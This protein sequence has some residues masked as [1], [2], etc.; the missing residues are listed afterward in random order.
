MK[1]NENPFLTESQIYRTS[2]CYSVAN[3][4]SGRIAVIDLG[5]VNAEIVILLSNQETVVATVSLK[6]FEAMNAKLNSPVTALVKESSIVLSSRDYAG[7]LSTRNSLCGK[8]HHITKGAVNADVSLTT[9][10]GLTLTANIAID[11]LEQIECQPGDEIWANFK[12][13][14]VILAVGNK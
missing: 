10:S 11:E 9:Q 12:A 1:H 13:S 7:L 6:A 2:T 3:Q 4:L 5:A 8:V 14:D